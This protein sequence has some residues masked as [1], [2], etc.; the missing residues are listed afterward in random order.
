MALHREERERM[1]HIAFDLRMDEVM[2][3]YLLRR[4]LLD[5][6]ELEEALREITSGSNAKWINEIARRALSQSPAH[7]EAEVGGE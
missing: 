6:Q 2:P 3:A 5:L 1:R 4:L 7:P